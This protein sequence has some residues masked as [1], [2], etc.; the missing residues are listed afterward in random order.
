MKA[1]LKE[2]LK[3]AMKAKDRVKMDTIRG[4]LTEI[5]YEEMKK[6]TEELPSTDY[7]TIMQREVKKRNEA[8]QFEEQAG[9]TEAK[10]TLKAEIAVIEAFLPKQM[11]NDVLEKIIVEL[12]T[13]TPDLSLNVVMKHLKES[14]AGQYDGKAASEIAKRVVG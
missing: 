7:T 14:Y 6:G 1:T 9:R 2:E 11:S 5:Q 8:M 13:A 4:V 10:E 12:K 3:L